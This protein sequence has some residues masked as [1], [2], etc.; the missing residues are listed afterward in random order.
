MHDLHVG[1]FTNDSS[2][3]RPSLHQGMSS[4]LPSHTVLPSSDQISSGHVDGDGT[5]ATAFIYPS[6]LLATFA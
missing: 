1:I 5:I 4:G 2:I 3:L 6:S